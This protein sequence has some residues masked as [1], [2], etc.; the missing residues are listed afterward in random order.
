M[1]RL[2]GPELNELRGIIERAFTLSQFDGLLFDRLD[3]TRERIALGDT[4]TDILRRVLIEANTKGW[5]PDLVKAIGAENPSD[6]DLV[7]F[8]ARHYGRGVT[9]PR[10]DLERIVIASNQFL[11]IARVLS[12]LGQIYRQVCRV[13]FG[14][15]ADPQGS[16]FLVGPSVVATN[17]HVMERVINGGVDPK[18]V[19]AQFDY[20]VL[21]DG[22]IDNGTRV[23]LADDWLIDSS[24]YVQKDVDGTGDEPTAEQLDYALIRLRRP[25][26][27]EPIG[28]KPTA[29]APPRGWMKLDEHGPVPAADTPVYIVQHPDGDPMKLAWE[30]RS[31]IG[32]NVAGTRLRHRTN[33]E[34]GSSGSPTFDANFAL[35]A[36]H[37]GGDPKSVTAKFNQGIPIGLIVD[38]LKKRNQY[39]AV[40]A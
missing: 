40:A 39:A 27:D 15:G 18:N 2:T 19:R 1:Q 22:T 38:L 28:E 30:T 37:N 31:V 21:P 26:G 32:L 14:G 20:A 29:D 7:D 24:P 4:S 35:I 8:A 9:A 23:E 36:L 33:T 10:N 25:I 34:H 13:S 12:R 17:F 3:R 16:G 11:D 6:S 5:L